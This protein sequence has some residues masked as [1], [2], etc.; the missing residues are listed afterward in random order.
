M[1]VFCSLLPKSILP[2]IIKRKESKSMS[3]SLSQKWIGTN[4]MFVQ[5]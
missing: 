3:P 4:D 5:A 2:F 1:Y